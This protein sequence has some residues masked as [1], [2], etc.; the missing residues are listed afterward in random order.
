MAK[1][2][3]KSISELVAMRTK[4][5]TLDQIEQITQ[6]IHTAKIAAD[7]NIPEQAVAPTEKVQHTV[8][9]DSFEEGANPKTSEGEQ[10]VKKDKNLTSGAPAKKAKT[11]EKTPKTT[12]ATEEEDID[13]RI[14]RISVHAPIGL[15]IKA[16]TKATLKN[17]TMMAYI[18]KLMENDL[19]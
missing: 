9:K 17:M 11:I 13:D 1:I 2:E 5:P 14:K 16:R 15:Y 19:K 18:L 8:R 7:L 6:D 4:K 10:N 12:I 3:K